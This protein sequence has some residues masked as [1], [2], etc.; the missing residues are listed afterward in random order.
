MLSMG[1]FWV[2]IIFLGKISIVKKNNHFKDNMF[3]F[4]ALFYCFYVI[5]KEN[6][7][8]KF[9]ILMVKNEYRWPLKS[10]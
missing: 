6:L 10:I 4:F 1:I 3:F 9:E 8:V 5:N 2:R 7:K